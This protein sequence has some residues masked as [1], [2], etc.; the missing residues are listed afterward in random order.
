MFP[1]TSSF[2]QSGLQWKLT[3]CSKKT[4]CRQNRQHETHI[5]RRNG[6]WTWTVVYALMFLFTY[7]HIKWLPQQM[8]SYRFGTVIDF[9]WGPKPGVHCGNSHTYSLVGGTISFILKSSLWYSTRCNTD[10]W[11][12]NCAKQNQTYV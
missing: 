8:F 12:L 4:C 9:H 3:S 5:T 11:I 10:E 1:C 7:L 6:H 2:I